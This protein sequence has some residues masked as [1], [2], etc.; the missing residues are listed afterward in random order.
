MSL[1]NHPTPGL[2]YVE[3]GRRRKRKSAK[4]IDG[5]STTK[6]KRI[7]RCWAALQ[8]R[9]PPPTRNARA[10]KRKPYHP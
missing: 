5:M 2:G 6:K 7:Q 10:E 8:L 1:L 9:S 3:G 4:I